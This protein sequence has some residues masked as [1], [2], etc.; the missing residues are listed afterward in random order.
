MFCSAF[1]L[2]TVAAALSILAL[3]PLPLAPL[4]SLAY[5]ACN[6]GEGVVRVHFPDELWQD[7]DERRLARQL[8]EAFDE[9]PIILTDRLANSVYLS[10]PAEAIFGDRAEALVN[11]L[12]LSL[13]GY[14]HK[15]RVPPGLLEAL[16]GEGKPWRGVVAIKG[17]SELPRLHF[18]EAS[19]VVCDGR[20]VTGLLR[21]GERQGAQQ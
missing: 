12:A 6:H 21:I 13:L 16:L 17:S 1:P 4:A 15:E 3:P 2:S 10:P 19:A 9:F 20:L 7:D 5:Q 18:V 11:R 8:A 14:G